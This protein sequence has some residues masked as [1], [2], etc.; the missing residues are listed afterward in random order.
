MSMLKGRSAKEE[1]RRT[2]AKLTVTSPLVLRPSTFKSGMVLFEAMLA[3][4]VFTMAA[5]ALVMA[6]NGCL[7]T[8]NARN[9]IELAV[10]GLENQMA[11]LHGSNIQPGETDAPDD[12]T[13]VAYHVSVE[14][15][16]DLRD[17]KGLPIP[18]TYRVTITA[19]WKAPN[20][21]LQT[22]SVSEMVFQP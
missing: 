4:F 15:A 16:Q 21:T 11:L 7:D 13:G 5:F 10:H 3:I 20:G 6:L 17:Q 9:R 22:R 12:G 8:A 14:Q 1:G 2:A 18:S 19:T